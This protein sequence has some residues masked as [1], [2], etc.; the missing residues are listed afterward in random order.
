MDKEKLIRK[1]RAVVSINIRV[2]KQ[3][4]KWLSENKY[5]PTAIFN[6]AIKDLGFKQ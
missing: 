5:S 6:E 3:V 2:T 4:S 1:E